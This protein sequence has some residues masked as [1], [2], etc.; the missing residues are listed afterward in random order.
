[1]GLFDRGAKPLVKE[2]DVLRALRTVQDP[3]LHRDLVSLGMIQN[4]AIEGSRVSFKIVL[5]TPACPAREQMKSQAMAAVG[6]LPGVGDVEVAVEAT[7][8]RTSGVPGGDR[9]AIE[10]V[11]NIFAVAS[12]K[13]GVGKTTVSV[14][15][16]VGLSQLGAR[17]GI[18][19]ADI[20]GP[21]I[22]L[23]MGI[24]QPPEAEG[25]KIIPL[26]SHGVKLMSIGFLVPEGTPV[27]WR[28]PLIHKAIEQFCHDV[29]WGE[30]DYLIID[31]PPGTGDATL[32]VAQSL[33]MA[34]VVIV[35]T[36]QDV[37]LLDARKSLATFQK[38]EVPILGI[39]ENM[40]Y[41]LCPH[42][43]ERVDIFGH[44]G[45]EQAAE[46]LAVP[47][48]GA[49][50]LNPSIRSGGDEGMPVVV[51]TPDAPESVAFRAVAGAVAARVS[52]L[53]MESKATVQAA[54]RGFRVLPMVGS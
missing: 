14:N 23:M 24:N 47:F 52:T 19:D 51:A 22:P 8:V 32:T 41:F 54:T 40:S 26:V 42:C 20:T 28:S 1:M 45:A 27:I 25:G 49:I 10:G 53:A 3:D 35:S 5:T 46:Q 39:V 9:Q 36:P 4:V 50:P 30:L 29:A 33:P 7:T 37:A 34:G 17:V 38:L 16:A 11:R 44:G 31:L 18:V 15:L 13:G 12:G 21:N 48:L 43:G 6:A 2:E